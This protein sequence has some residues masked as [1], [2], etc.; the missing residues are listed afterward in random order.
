M[1]L[2]GRDKKL[3]SAFSMECHITYLWL[4]SGA[5]SCRLWRHWV[6][7]LPSPPAS[8]ERL[9]MAGRREGQKNK[10]NRVNPW[11]RLGMQWIHFNA[12]AWLQGKQ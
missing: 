12:L 4:Y 8:P 7:V 3:G 2:R 1:P 10:K 5:F 6:F 9:A 11:P